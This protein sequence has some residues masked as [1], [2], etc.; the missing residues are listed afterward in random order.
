MTPAY[1]ATVTADGATVTAATRVGPTWGAAVKYPDIADTKTGTQQAWKRLSDA[2]VRVNGFN[3]LTF[4]HGYIPGPCTDIMSTKYG[5]VFDAGLGLW[6]NSKPPIDDIPASVDAVRKL[7]R[8]AK[9]RGP[10]WLTWQHEMSNP[11]KGIPPT[12]G[13]PHQVACLQAALDER[14]RIGADNVELAY[15]EMA[16]LNLVNTATDPTHRDPADWELGR[17]GLTAEQKTRVIAAPDAY[18]KAKSGGF[19]SFA[20]ACGPA[21]DWY[22]AHG[23]TRL[24]IG[25]VAVNN[26]AGVPESAAAAAVADVVS[27]ATARRLEIAAWFVVDDADGAAGVRGKLTESDARL[28]EAA[29]V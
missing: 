27:Y 3:P 15:V 4:L 24:G 29:K 9:G 23:W 13:G 11:S 6:L 18:I 5:W 14:D 7:V 8:S 16:Y 28:R 20:S 25:E 19:G 12:K 26:D 10:V 1:T 17:Y 21:H 2:M 22:S